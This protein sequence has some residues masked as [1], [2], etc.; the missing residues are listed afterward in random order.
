MIRVYLLSF[1][2]LLGL[3]VFA[4][5]KTDSIK[6]LEIKHSFFA[7]VYTGFYYSFSDKAVPRAGFDFSTGLLGYKADWGDKATVT[8]IY[9]VTK[10]TTDI[11]VQDTANRPL[12]VNYF[13][14]SD[15][16]AFL[17][18]AE[19]DFKPRKWLEISVGQLLNQ[20]YLT[21]QDKFWGF[22][23]VATTFQEFYRFGSPADFGTRVTLKLKDKLNFS[24]GAVNGEGP[25]RKQDNDATLQYFTNIGYMP[26][27]GFI[28]KVFADYLPIDGRPA[29]SAISFFTGYRCTDW[30]IGV[31]YNHVENNLYT[32]GN[33][34][35]GTSVYGAYKIADKWNILARHDYLIKTSTYEKAHYIIAGC[36]YEPYK[37]IYVALNGRFL[38]EGEVPWIY[39]NFGAKF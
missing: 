21:Y 39:M 34:L 8:L 19:I 15:Y 12:T 20:Q 6:P 10:T 17:K 3:S 30:R 37:G 2:F 1:S 14:G 9:D 22:R 29:R 35:Q 33:T 24:L 28:V 11:T 25:F 5:E 18:M 36:E 16:T 32:I 38:S 23:Y 26:V 13:K 4:Q 31:E 27:K 7:N